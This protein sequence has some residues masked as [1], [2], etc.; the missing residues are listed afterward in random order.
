MCIMID[1]FVNICDFADIYT[2]ITIT[3]LC[4]DNYAQ[5]KYITSKPLFCNDIF[6]KP[7]ELFFTSKRL[8]QFF[9]WNIHYSFVVIYDARFDYIRPSQQILIHN[10]RVVFVNC[11]FY[12]SNVKRLLCLESAQVHFY[13]CTIYTRTFAKLLQNS[14]IRIEHSDIYSFQE[15]LP[16]IVLRNSSIMCNS[17]TTFGGNV[18][19]FV[20]GRSQRL[21]IFDCK[22]GSKNGIEFFK[23]TVPHSIIE[24]SS[25]KKNMLLYTFNTRHFT[26]M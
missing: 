16:L 8:C 1:I 3:S 22:F 20:N 17:C 21:E 4:K 12:T 26:Q 2:K 11:K 24:K 18:A 5:R 23:C 15:K 9:K 7:N 25:S 13:K 6:A 10:S 19:I 14:F